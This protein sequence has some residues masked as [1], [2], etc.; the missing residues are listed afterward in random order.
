MQQ[1]IVARSGLGDSAFCTVDAEV[2]RRKPVQESTQY[3]SN[4]IALRSK[5]ECIRLGKG[6]KIYEW[7]TSRLER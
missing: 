3:V 5:D 7:A 2:S 1:D 4:S 6:H